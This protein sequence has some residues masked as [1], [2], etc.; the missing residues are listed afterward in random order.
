MEI[1]YLLS[2]TTKKSKETFWIF[3]Y[4]ERM[5]SLVDRL[6]YLVSRQEEA[7]KSI[8]EKVNNIKSAHKEIM[9]LEPNL[10]NSFTRM[11]K[12]EIVVFEL[13][14]RIN[15]KEDEIRCKKKIF[16]A[17][18]CSNLTKK[19]PEKCQWKL[20]WYHFCQIQTS[21]YFFKSSKIVKYETLFW[22]S[23]SIEKRFLYIMFLMTLPT[24]L[25]FNPIL[26]RLSKVSWMYNCT[27]CN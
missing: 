5:I 9:E 16:L 6:K 26:H 13:E 11:R 8:K 15:R 21:F 12:I 19:F 27:N 18:T 10:R 20:F 4:R 25:F 22:I 1:N 17:K 3:R 24:F 23:K 7:K 14:D 2:K